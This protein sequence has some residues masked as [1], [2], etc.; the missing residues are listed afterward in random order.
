MSRCLKEAHS[1]PRI[2][3]S[4]FGLCVLFFCAQISAGETVSKGELPLFWWKE[5]NFINF[6]DHLSYQ[7][8]QRIV[9]GPLKYYNKKDLN[10]S[11]KLL[12]LGSILYFA[13][14][15]DVVWGSGVNGKRL[16]KKDYTFKKLDVRAVRGPFTRDFLIKNFQL[17]VPE[18]YG[19][20]AML[21]PYLFPEFTRNPTPSLD[22]VVVV[23][24]LDIP[25]FIGQ[26]DPHIVFATEPWDVVLNKILD[27]RF[28]I[29]SSL[30]GIVL[31]EAYG[32]PARY[33]RLTENEPLLKFFD[34]YLGSNRASFDYA[35]SIEEAL[36]MGGEPAASCDLEK[37][38]N[39]FPIEF[40]PGKSLPIIQFKSGIKK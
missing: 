20:P 7:I 31:A 1:L 26:N 37:L 10:Q 3:C 5:G 13:N 19:D 16:D 27:S 39:A 24:Y 36:C 8:V 22:Y 30:H 12:A 25:L 9:R 6:G 17:N 15:G 2:L 21:V 32:I 28:V 4:L 18:I 40:W 33:V 34:Y 14:E 23:H 11:K 29:S 35:R 38:Y